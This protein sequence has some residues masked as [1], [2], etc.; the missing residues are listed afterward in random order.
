MRTILLLYACSVAALG[1]GTLGAPDPK[2]EEA[3]ELKACAQM[4]LDGVMKI[5]DVRSQRFLGKVSSDS[6]LCRGGE[7]SLQFRM[8]PWVD[9]SQYWGTGDMSSLPTGYLTKK[10]P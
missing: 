4:V 5:P 9:W 1:A 8:T 10:G 6:M 7:K 3:R 2:V